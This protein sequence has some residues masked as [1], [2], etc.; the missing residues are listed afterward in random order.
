M[1]HDAPEISAN[2]DEDA[3]ALAEAVPAPRPLHPNAGALGDQLRN[4]GGFIDALRK[5]FEVGIAGGSA[6]HLQ[7]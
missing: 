1:V 3:N 7:Y 6:A 5:Y 4:E 2:V